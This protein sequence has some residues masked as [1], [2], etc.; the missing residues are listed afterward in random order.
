MKDK[1]D[2]I[3]KERINYIIEKNGDVV[4]YSVNTPVL[5]QGKNMDDMKRK[6]KILMKSYVKGL[7][8]T[9][10]LEEPFEFVNIND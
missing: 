7:Q 10:D 4:G 5:V 2:K 3:F 9:L 6:I 8:E 1:S